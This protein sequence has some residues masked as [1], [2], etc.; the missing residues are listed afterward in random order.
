MTQKKAGPAKATT[1]KA[2]RKAPATRKKPA[3][4]GPAKPQAQKVTPGIK[5]G[6]SL[7][8]KSGRTITKAA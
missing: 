4:K 7:A 2:K 3:G 8:L 1:S 6:E 5:P